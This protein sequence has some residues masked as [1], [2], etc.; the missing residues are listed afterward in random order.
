MSA[1]SHATSGRT[2]ASKRVPEGSGQSSGRCGDQI[3]QRARVWLLLVQADPT[4]G[5][6]CAVGPEVT[7][8]P[9]SD[10]GGPQRAMVSVTVTCGWYTTAPMEPSVGRRSQ[11]TCAEKALDRFRLAAWSA[12][13]AANR[14]RA[15]P[16]AGSYSSFCLAWPWAPVRRAASR[17]STQHYSDNLL[18]IGV[19]QA[20]SARRPHAR[21]GAW[22]RR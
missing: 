5:G 12:R 18:S 21:R 15:H 10:H 9:R 16:T 7:G 6:H 20:S 22:P 8:R 4:V 2:R 1:S 14:G 3:I 13:P 17:H 11:A 19:L